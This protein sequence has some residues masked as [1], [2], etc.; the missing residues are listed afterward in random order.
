MGISR[1]PV[2]INLTQR[3]EDAKIKNNLKKKIVTE[4]EIAKI[5]VDAAWYHKGCQWIINLKS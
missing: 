5:I 4:N 1:G 2:N 3:R